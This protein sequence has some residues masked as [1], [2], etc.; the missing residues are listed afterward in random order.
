MELSKDYFRELTEKT[1]L[2][3]EKIAV[4]T[5]LFYIE[6][7]LM[8]FKARLKMYEDAEV[9]AKVNLDQSGVDHHQGAIRVSLE[10]IAGL[11]KLQTEIKRSCKKKT[12]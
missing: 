10:A 7:R 9:Q 8:H 12:R 1:Y 11:E 5:V 3:V 4:G 2:D 6:H